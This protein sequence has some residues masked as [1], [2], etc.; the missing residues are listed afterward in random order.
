MRLK[1]WL[2][3]PI[4]T[5]HY[6]VP[7]LSSTVWN[8][9]NLDITVINLPAD[10]SWQW[11]ASFSTWNPCQHEKRTQ[12]YVTADSLPRDVS[13]WGNLKQIISWTSLRLQSTTETTVSE[14]E[15]S[16]LK[17]EITPYFAS[18]KA[19]KNPNKRIPQIIG[20]LENMLE[21][22]HSF[23]RFLATRI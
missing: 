10:K 4:D 21:V 20:R 19:C 22:W 7:I 23:S 13:F 16:N 12:F 17:T 18:R 8:F 2:K 6:S 11:T 15:K 3:A 14:R 1:K 9:L 5:A